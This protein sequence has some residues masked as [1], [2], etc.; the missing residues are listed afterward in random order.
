MAEKYFYNSKTCRYEKIKKNLTTKIISCISI[1]SFISIILTILFYEDLFVNK[2][3]KSLLQKNKEL[4]YSYQYIE[5]KVN[6]LKEDLKYL[7][8]RDNNIYRTILEADPIPMEVREAG[9]GGSINR[10]TILSNIDEGE[11][12]LSIEQKIDKLRGY[13]QVQKESYNEL[14]KLANDKEKL[15]RQIPSIQPI[16]NK[17]LTRL[18]S[19][20]G[21]RIH[22]IYKV[23]RMHNGIDFTAP[24]GTPIYATGEGRVKK[25][26]RVRGYG[27]IVKIA[28]GDNY[29]T[30]YAHL[31]QQ[32]VKV[33]QLVKRGEEIG[34]VGI[35]GLATAPH[36]HYEVF[37]K[38]KRVDPAEYFFNDLEPEEYDEIIRLASIENQS[39]GY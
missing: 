22:P 27:K 14:S 37:Y 7:Q 10:N 9:T 39:L 31:S 29:I 15:L 18:A 35:T 28:H 33:G 36:L 13:I 19:G 20:Y 17:E 11:I 5:E 1:V 30:L 24:R 2:R 25:V 23:R 4:Q 8:E 21:F 38:G 3:E 6:N 32:K 26:G 12:K 16:S 34:E